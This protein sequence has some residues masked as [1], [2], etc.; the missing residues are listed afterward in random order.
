MKND[1][2]ELKEKIISNAKNEAESLLSRAK[3]AEGRI[4]IQAREEE[5]KIKEEAEKKGKLLFEKEKTRM[6]SKKKMDEKKEFFHLRNKLFEL[7]R[8]DLEENLVLMFKDGELD[9]WIKSCCRDVIEKEKKALLVV[10]KVDLRNFKKICSGIESLNFASEPITAG[11][12]IRSG[13]NEYDFRFSLLANN[14]LKQNIKIIAAKLG[15]IGG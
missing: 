15:V 13:E 10:R 1:I 11:F 12:L 3:K 4:L 9:S 14:I 7:L 5:K 6:V 2:N 8:K